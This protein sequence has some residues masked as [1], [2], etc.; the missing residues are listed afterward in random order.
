MDSIV[1][2]PYASA[3]AMGKSSHRMASSHPKI[4]KIGHGTRHQKIK[5]ALLCT[6]RN[7]KSYCILS[8]RAAKLR[9]QLQQTTSKLHQSE[10]TIATLRAQLRHAQSKWVFFQKLYIQEAAA[11]QRDCPDCK[12][13]CCYY[14]ASVDFNLTYICQTHTLLNKRSR[15]SEIIS[16][17]STSILSQLGTR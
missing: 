15:I 4:R 17:C 1:K 12:F 11:A 5:Q 10:Q 8:S 7:N 3:M 6:Q 9:Y 2:A 14:I 16:S 13:I